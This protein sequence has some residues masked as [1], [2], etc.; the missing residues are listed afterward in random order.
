[1]PFHQPDQLPVISRG[2]EIARRMDPMVNQNFR[3]VEKPA[4]SPGEADAQVK[5]FDSL[6]IDIPAVLRL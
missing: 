6:K 4:S 1:M 3:D 2:V 5:V